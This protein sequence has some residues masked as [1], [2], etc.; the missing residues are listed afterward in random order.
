MPQ[1]LQDRIRQRL[2]AIE[3]AGQLRRLEPPAGIDLS[4]NDYLGLS[5]HPR[6]TSRMADAVAREG[7]GATAARLLRGDRE[8]FTAIERR[9][10]EFKQTDRALFFGS[11][12]AANVGLLAT[13]LEA[14]D[15]VFSD[16]LNHAS[17]ID[18]IR[19][20]KA[21]RR[22]FPHADLD[23]LAMQLRGAP[24]AGQKFLVTESLFG[25]DG[26]IA[27]LVQ[28]A[29]LC[30]ET[31]TNLI[32]DEAHAVGV[33]GDRASGL[34]EHTGIGEQVFLSTNTAG[35]ALGVAGAFIAGADWAIEYL[36]QRARTFMF[37]TA[38]PPAMAAA[39]DAALDVLRDEPERRERLRSNV[40]L[41]RELLE[42][43]GV[44]VPRDE[45]HIIPIFIG[46]SG[47]AVAVAG[48]VRAAGFDARAVRP[49]T[50]PEGTARLRI[51][52]NA[53]LT[54][55]QVR[56]FVDAL[57]TALGGKVNAAAQ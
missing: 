12:Y 41:L 50:V 5:R 1:G 16:E 14:G 47:A 35:K 17:L 36:V 34:I 25:M 24:S 43:A 51:S 21:E 20:S 56:G 37:S 10:A 28:Y 38:P 4:S 30:R 26:D 31:N 52:V 2:A 44:P 32:V 18:G 11:G 39:I 27:P 15:V 6:I 3:T 33:F 42:P 55:P 19:V 57:I 13:F 53:T 7:T 22:I 8:C 46:D 54:E 29:E 23:E 9:F 49:P 45:T 40:R 48:Q